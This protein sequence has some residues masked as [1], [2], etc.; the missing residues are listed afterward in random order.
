MKPEDA[1]KVLDIL[2]LIDET[3]KGPNA[4]LVNTHILKSVLKRL[5]KD[6]AS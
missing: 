6:I 5:I 4:A 3:D 1:R 2:D